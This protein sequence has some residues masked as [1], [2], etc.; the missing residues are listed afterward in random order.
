MSICGSR[1]TMTWMVQALNHPDRHEESIQLSRINLNP[2]RTRLTVSDT[3]KCSPMAIQPSEPRDNQ[4]NRDSQAY[5][6]P[7]CYDSRPRSNH[8]SAAIILIVY[9]W[10]VL[11]LILKFLM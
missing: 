11:F 5:L 10:G 6:L 4:S 8:T 1:K 9:S 3:L 7:I 2:P